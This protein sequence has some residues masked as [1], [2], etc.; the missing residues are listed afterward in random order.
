[1]TRRLIVLAIVALL[2]AAIVAVAIASAPL[3]RDAALREL[4]AAG[5]TDAQ[6]ASASLAP[7]GLHF[8]D[9]TLDEGGALHV[10][11]VVLPWSLDLLRGVVN[12]ATLIG[13]R[14]VVDARSAATGAK[15]FAWGPAPPL[16]LVLRGAT[17]VVLNDAEAV[18]LAFDATTAS[19][20]PA[21]AVRFTGNGTFHHDGNLVVPLAT[22]L[23]VDWTAAGLTVN[24]RLT[25]AASGLDVTLAGTVQ[26]GAG[27]GDLRVS[28][29]TLRLA[30]Q[31]SLAAISPVLARTLAS[32]VH[33]VSG[34]VTP[35]G[36]LAWRPGA[37]ATT[38]ARVQLADIAFVSSHG[39]ASGVSGAVAFADLSPLRLDGTQRLRVARAEASV[40]LGD[41]ELELRQNAAGTPVVN[42]IAATALGGRVE[43]GPIT[44]SL[45]RQRTTVRFR[46]VGVTDVLALGGPAGLS[47]EGKLSG[48]LTIDV[49]PDQVGLDHGELAATGPGRLSYTPSDPSSLG[50]QAATVLAVLSDFH[51]Q[52]LTITFARSGEGAAAQLAGRMRV[53]GNNPGFQDGHP[54]V[55]NVNLSGD[56]EQTLQAALG[57]YR[58][59]AEIMRAAR[60]LE[61]RAP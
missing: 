6:V 3:L 30:P 57:L 27:T 40:A 24:G 21:G 45:A 42:R 7:D 49:S 39:R 26:P 4:R 5:F 46:D 52:R 23:T 32:L 34:Q 10:D 50:E 43:A 48:D 47:G 53:E 54:V 60:S 38:T 44:V 33:D 12:G 2:G 31:H 37:A 11:E 51:Y 36:R 14:V 25:D 1:M 41:I 18:W 20:G 22:A 13:A 28:A 9:I 61:P 16:S 59:P 29:T 35:E 56:I 55:L 19:N 8:A 17:L 58:L 15:A